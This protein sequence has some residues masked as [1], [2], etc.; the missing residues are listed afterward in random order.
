M[1][2]MPTRFRRRCAYTIPAVMAAGRAGGMVMVMMSRDSM[3]MVF[4]GTWTRSKEK[5]VKSAGSTRTF[6]PLK[7]QPYPAHDA[8]HDGV[9]EADPCNPDQTQ[10]EQ[11]RVSIQLEVCGFGVQDGAHQLAFL[12]GEAC[13]D[14][15]GF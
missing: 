8:E 6:H 1:Q 3:M 9:D 13:G 15:I 10:Q 14:H 7:E 11:V 5:Q 12:C 2:K 4:A